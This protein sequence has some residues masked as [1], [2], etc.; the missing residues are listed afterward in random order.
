MF[1]CAL[2]L[3]VHFAFL[4]VVHLATFLVVHLAM[5]LVMCLAKCLTQSESLNETA[6]KSSLGKFYLCPLR[7][8]RGRYSRRPLGIWLEM[9][10]CVFGG[11]LVGELEVK[12][13]FSTR[14]QSVFTDYCVRVAHFAVH[15]VYTEC[16]HRM[17]RQ[18]VQ[19]SYYKANLDEIPCDYALF[20]RII[21]DLTDPTGLTNE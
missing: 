12:A 3:S 2:A 7:M 1:R 9:F 20:L 10:T 5:F 17:Y 21:R 6:A 13:F 4:F 11:F 16:I 15:R 8:Q 14:I 19:T 18:W